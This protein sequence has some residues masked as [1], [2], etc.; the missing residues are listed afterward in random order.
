MGHLFLAV[1]LPPSLSLIPLVSVF[2]RFLRPVLVLGN[3]LV[4]VLVLCVCVCVCA[5]VCLV[6]VSLCFMEMSLGPRFRP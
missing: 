3:A 6:D 1:S 5:C 4:L 2:T